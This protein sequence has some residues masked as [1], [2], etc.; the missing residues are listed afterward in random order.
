MGHFTP[1]LLPISGTLAF[2]CVG[3]SYYD[4][5]NG[6]NENS[7]RDDEWLNTLG[8][9]KTRSNESHSKNRLWYDSP[10]VHH[11]FRLVDLDSGR[12]LTET[13]EIHTLELRWYNLEES[14]LEAANTL[15][16][17]LYWLLN[18]HQYD[19]ES[20]AKL[21]LQPAF[22]KSDRHNRPNCEKDGGQSHVRYTRK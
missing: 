15:D 11:T 20:L 21:F 14:E 13:L 16:R 19:A 7:G 18:A 3:K 5:R 4:D 12:F 1:F 6:V 10:K 8:D 17:R 2:F 22:Q 9:L